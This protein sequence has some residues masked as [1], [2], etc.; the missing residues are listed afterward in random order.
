MLDL[1]RL[2]PPITRDRE[3]VT[4]AGDKVGLGE[5]HAQPTGAVV[6]E[7][8]AG[9]K[10]RMGPLEQRRAVLFEDDRLLNDQQRTGAEPFA[11][12]IGVIRCDEVPVRTVGGATRQIDHAGPSAARTRGGRS[13]VASAE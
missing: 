9:G 2:R 5:P 13:T 11:G 1:I 4:A 12:T 3:A 10:V 7:V 8:H 6:V